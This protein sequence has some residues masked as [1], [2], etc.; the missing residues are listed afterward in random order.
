MNPKEKAQLIVFKT[1]DAVL[2]DKKKMS[3]NQHKTIIWLAE[4]LVE[5]ILEENHKLDDYG[6]LSTQLLTA[7]YCFWEDVRKEIKLL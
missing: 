7:R 3:K 6:V 1:A 5:E 4:R 2:N